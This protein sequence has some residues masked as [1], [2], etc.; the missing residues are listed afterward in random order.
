MVSK[1]FAL[2]ACTYEFRSPRWQRKHWPLAQSFLA[3]V[4]RRVIQIVDG[5][6]AIQSARIMALNCFWKLP[7]N[8]LEKMAEYEGLTDLHKVTLVDL[9]FL[10]IQTILK[11]SVDHP[12]F[13]F[14]YVYQDGKNRFSSK[15][16]L[17]GFVHQP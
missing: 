6:L 15:K 11:N 14:I 12:L 1:P 7:R 10:L 5:L 2:V 16:G 9:L 3:P 17:G 8:W 13:I 4:G